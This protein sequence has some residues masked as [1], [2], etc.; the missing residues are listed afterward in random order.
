MTVAC[1][2]TFSWKRETEKGPI[3]MLT[4]YFFMNVLTLEEN[5]LLVS[6]AM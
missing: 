2:S 5:R 1:L 4:V 3:F 6:N